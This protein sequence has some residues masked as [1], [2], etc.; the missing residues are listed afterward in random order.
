VHWFCFWLGW[1]ALSVGWLVVAASFFVS[2]FERR[3]RSFAR[4][5]GRIA[6]RLPIPELVDRRPPEFVVTIT[7]VSAELQHESLLSGFVQSSG[8]DEM[9][10]LSAVNPLNVGKTAVGAGRKLVDVGVGVGK[11]VVGAV[12]PLNLGQNVDR[13]KKLARLRTRM[14]LPD[15]F[16]S[17]EFGSE[18]EKTQ[19]QKGTLQVPRALP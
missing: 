10:P 2:R 7:V 4:S 11:E 3:R 13:L 1:R 15:P 19:V 17:V 6:H 14:G 5:A 12:N 9:N 18:R 16:V 8:L